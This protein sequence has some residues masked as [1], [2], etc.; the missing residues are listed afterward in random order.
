MV[1]FSRP[2]PLRSAR[3]IPIDAGRREKSILPLRSVKGLATPQRRKVK[4]AGAPRLEVLTGGTTFTRAAVAG[5]ASLNEGLRRDGP[6]RVSGGAQEGPPSL[7]RLGQPLWS[8][9]VPVP[10]KMRWA[11]RKVKPNNSRLSAVTPCNRRKH[12]ALVCLTASQFPVPCFQAL[13]GPLSRKCPEES[14]SSP[15]PHP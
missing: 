8:G 15:I 7:L 11:A 9:F 6:R 14:L 5:A 12:R 1:R 4:P 2:G 13:G 10:C 3:F